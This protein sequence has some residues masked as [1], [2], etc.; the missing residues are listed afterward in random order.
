MPVKF[1][2]FSVCSNRNA[3]TRENGFVP[4]IGHL[5]GCFHNW[6]QSKKIPQHMVETEM[7]DN[8]DNEKRRNILVKI[9]LEL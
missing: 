6:F 5:P 2:K 3:M 7:Q 8:R 1:H 9:I 4:H